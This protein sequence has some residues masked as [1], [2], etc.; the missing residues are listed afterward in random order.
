MLQLVLSQPVP[1]ST[2]DISASS[3]S[4][5]GAR[6][7]HRRKG[8]AATR[9]AILVICNSGFDGSEQ[10]PGVSFPGPFRGLLG[11]VTLLSA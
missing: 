5:L 6:Q 8:S 3:S 11:C 7:P 10:G 1:A 2:N 4:V 9:S